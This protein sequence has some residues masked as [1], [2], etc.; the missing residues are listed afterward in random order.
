MEADSNPERVEGTST[1]SDLLARYFLRVDGFGVSGKG[2]SLSARYRSGGKVYQSHPDENAWLNALE[3]RW[4]VLPGASVN[5]RWFH[6]YTQVSAKDRTE[7]GH[8]RDYFRARA[9]GGLGLELGPVTLRGG[10][11]S[12]WFLYKPDGQLS[13]T[14][15]TVNGSISWRIAES[16]SLDLGG[17]RAWREYRSVRRV[18]STRGGQIF[19]DPDG[20]LRRDVATYLSGGVSYRGPLIVDLQGTWYENDA[21]SYGQSLVRAGGNLTLTS[22]LFAGFIGSVRL[23]LQRTAYADPIPLDPTLEVDDDNRNSL[24]V[25]LTRNL[26]EDVGLTARYSLYAQEFGTAETDF[27]RQLFFLGLS[28]EQL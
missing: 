21:N 14:G 27:S 28:W 26:Y 6:I 22:P 25:E 11:A 12:T 3:A 17:Q 2:Q 9:G 7:K 23:G 10:G 13:N 1:P 20:A 19:P 4:T 18:E 16:W 5:E 24:V 8:Q 15:P